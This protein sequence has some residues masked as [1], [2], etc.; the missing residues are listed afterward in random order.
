MCFG[1][2][3]C[4]KE[5]SLWFWSFLGEL[6]SSSISIFF[7]LFIFVCLFVLCLSACEYMPALM[8]AVGS[9]LPPCRTRGPSEGSKLSSKGL[10]LLTCPEVLIVFR[11]QICPSFNFTVLSKADR[12]RENP[13][14]LRANTSLVILFFLAFYRFIF[15]FHPCGFYFLDSRIK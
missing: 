9:L 12:E 13:L 15:Y 10:Y 8:P 6:K 5:P 11:D 4:L 3:M 1:C 14:F 7:I 2:H